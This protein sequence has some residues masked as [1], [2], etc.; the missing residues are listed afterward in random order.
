MAGY[1]LEDRSIIMNCPVNY[2]DN[3]EFDEASYENKPDEFTFARVGAP[4]SKFDDAHFASPEG[5]IGGTP[6][7][8][9]PSDLPI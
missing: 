3:G 7:V 1:S 8:S 6:K 9:E 4:T 2:M 5:V